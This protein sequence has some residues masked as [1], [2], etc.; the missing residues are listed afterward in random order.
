[1]KI[2]HHFKS[3]IEKHMSSKFLLNL[4]RYNKYSI[5]FNKKCLCRKTIH[6]EQDLLTDQ[7]WKDNCDQYD[8]ISIDLIADEFDDEAESLVEYFEN[9]AR[10]GEKTILE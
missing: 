7:V 8:L 3:K 1:M 5:H 6:N 9:L 4:K 10:R 2:D